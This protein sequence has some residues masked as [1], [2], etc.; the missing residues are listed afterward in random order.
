MLRKEGFTVLEAADGSEAFRM[1]GVHAAEITAMF[2][3]V[4]LPGI[5]SPK[6]LREAR[7]LRPDLRVIVTSAYSEQKVA[8]MSSDLGAHPFVRKPYRLVDFLKVL[9]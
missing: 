3:D 9:S 6:I 4:T 5:A 2:L 7:R 8:A 1:V